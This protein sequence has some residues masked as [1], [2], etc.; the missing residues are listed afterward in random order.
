[1]ATP[2]AYEYSLARDKIWATAMT[3]VAAAETL[4]T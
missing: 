1:M 4:D 2:T 3:Y